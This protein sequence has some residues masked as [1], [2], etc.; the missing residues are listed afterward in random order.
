[1]EIKVLSSKDYEEKEKNYG[2]CIIIHHNANVI[3]YDCGSEEHAIRVKEFLK[4]KNISD[5]Y[6][7]LSH[8]DED[9]FKGIQW[10]RENIEIKG[11]YTILLLKYVDE[12][13]EE[14]NDKRRTKEAI[15]EQILEL[16]DNVA[17]LSGENLKD[18]YE[19]SINID[20]IDIVGPDKEYMI[21]AVAH[22][23]DGRE[24]DQIDS[25]TIFNAISVQ[26]KLNINGKMILL[27]GDASYPSI[28]DKI[29]KYDS[30][31]LPHH[32]KSKQAEEIFDK[33]AEK[34]SKITYIVSDNTGNSNG[35]S[36]DLDTK[37][38]IVYNTK[39]YGDIDVDKV[40]ENK[41]S[42][43]TYGEKNDIYT[44]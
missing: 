15:K 12:I 24:G 13:Y 33:L 39:N 29:D 27:T 42:A 37:G 38:K 17:K 30:I 3:V 6:V 11:I 16:Y 31:Q 21:S 40:I 4:E 41:R 23:L 14:I 19:E 10:L 5:V 36:D 1:M 22:Q 20:G 34:N 26:V 2:D 18:I 35:G 32:G 7:I 44:V 9:H 25:E 28:E 8:N 43:G